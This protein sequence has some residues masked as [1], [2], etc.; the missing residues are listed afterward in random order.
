MFRCP[1]NM[2]KP[3]KNK[4]VDVLYINGENDHIPLGFF[5]LILSSVKNLV[6]N[7]FYQFLLTAI[8]TMD[9]ND[10]FAKA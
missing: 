7:R 9:C 6:A 1:E 2:D 10:L 8:P 3:E 5:E 4:N